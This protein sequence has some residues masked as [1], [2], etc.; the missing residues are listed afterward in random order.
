[1]QVGCDESALVCSVRPLELQTMSNFLA[2]AGTLVMTSEASKCRNKTNLCAWSHKGHTS[3]VCVLSLFNQ[4]VATALW[5]NSG[6]FCWS[7]LL[8]SLVQAPE[9]SLSPAVLL[10]LSEQPFQSTAH[11]SFIGTWVCHVSWLGGR[12]TTNSPH[13]EWVECV[14]MWRGV[15]VCVCSRQIHYWFKI[16]KENEDRQSN[17]STSCIVWIYFLNIPCD[18][19]WPPPFIEA[20]SPSSTCS[21]RTTKSR[22]SLQASHVFR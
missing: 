19:G 11:S 15:C 4:G 3:K 1:M 13:L 10:Y 16:L 18:S 6:R 8:F 9:K 22:I 7:F 21:P 20:D 14:F 5:E 2:E 12:P 17:N